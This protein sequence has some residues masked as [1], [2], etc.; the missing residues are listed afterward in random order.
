[1]YHILCLYHLFN[2]NWLGLFSREPTR[3]I[4]ELDKVLSYNNLL[5]SLKNH[6]DASRF[7][8]GIGPVSLVGMYVDDLVW[9]FL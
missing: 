6:A 4:E 2:S 1:M 9:L 3:V 5:I 7:A 8:P